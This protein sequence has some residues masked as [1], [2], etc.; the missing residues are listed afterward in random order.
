M[1]NKMKIETK[2]LPSGKCQVKFTMD[3]QKKTYGYVLVEPN[4][5]LSDVI[6]EIKERIAAKRD[7]LSIFKHLSLTQRWKDDHNFLLFEA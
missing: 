2:K 4:R 1:E 5:K 7:N 3:G 6:D